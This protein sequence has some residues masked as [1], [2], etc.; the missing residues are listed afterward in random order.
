MV[1]LHSLQPLFIPSVLSSMIYC[2][3]VSLMTSVLLHNSSRGEQ[4]HSPRV[5]VVDAVG[6]HVGVAV[7]L[8]Q[9]DIKIRH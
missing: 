2:S 6:G 9:T 8:P 4:K 7:N 5:N 1:S 3:D